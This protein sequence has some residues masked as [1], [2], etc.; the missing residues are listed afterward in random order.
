MSVPIPK[1]CLTVLKQQWIIVLPDGT[2]HADGV[3]YHL[4]EADRNSM[5]EEVAGRLGTDMSDA[6]EEPIG[7]PA[8][9]YATPEYHQL[10]QRSRFGLRVK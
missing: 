7:D 4:T 8:P 6:R 3:S 10:I 2:T 5:V 1:N 9:I